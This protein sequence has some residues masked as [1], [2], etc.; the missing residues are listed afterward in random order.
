M[1]ASVPEHHVAAESP[2]STSQPAR[3]RSG[4]RGGAVHR[5]DPGCVAAP[6]PPMEMETTLDGAVEQEEQDNDAVVATLEEELARVREKLR[7]A[8][9]GRPLVSH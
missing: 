4:Y 5:D 3:Y 6:R 8:A 1:M 9:T 7:A 2:G